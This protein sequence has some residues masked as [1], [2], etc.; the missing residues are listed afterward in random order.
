MDA[1]K[2]TVNDASTFVTRLVQVLNGGRIGGGREGEEDDGERR[3]RMERR[4]RRRNGDRFG[5]LKYLFY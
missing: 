3:R 1:L 5:D 4:R 2:K